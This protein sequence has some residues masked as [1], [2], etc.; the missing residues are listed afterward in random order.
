ML[1]YAK[2]AELAPLSKQQLPVRSEEFHRPI[3]SYEPAADQ[4]SDILKN[5]SFN[6]VSNIE[7]KD[8]RKIRLDV[9]LKRTIEERRKAAELRR[10]QDEKKEDGKLH[11]SWVSK[12]TAGSVSCDI[13]THKYNDGLDGERMKRNDERKL[14]LKEC[15]N[16]YTYTRQT[17]S[18]YNPITGQQM[19]YYPAT[20]KPPSWMQT[21][22]QSAGSVEQYSRSHSDSSS[23]T[24]FP[25]L[26]LLEPKPAED[27]C[28]S[29]TSTAFT[30]SSYSP[31]DPAAL[32]RRSRG[33][34]FYS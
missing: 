15:R 4:I 17:R 32:P 24:V 20:P 33:R 6:Q 2:H 25:S 16:Y 12:R 8:P 5:P 1:S 28:S 3:R 18:S 31:S 34:A 30:S 21:L 11:P 27:V 10:I 23:K 7:P 19:T 22:P 13:I 26:P 14:Y 9:H 29:S